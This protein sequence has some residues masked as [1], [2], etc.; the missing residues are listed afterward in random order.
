MRNGKKVAVII[1]AYNEESS[2]GKVIE[3]V[4]AWVDDLLVVDNGSGDRTRE[5]AERSGRVRIV[6]QPA[7]GTAQPVRRV[8]L[9]P[10]VPIFWCFSMPT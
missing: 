2:I 5:A 4:P 9:P 6:E 10:A 7:G 3:A 1:P 8:L